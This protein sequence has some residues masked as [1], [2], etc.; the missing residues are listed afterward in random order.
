MPPEPLPFAEPFAAGLLDPA[1]AAPGLIGDAAGRLAGKRYDVYRNNVT[2]GLAKTIESIFPAVRHWVGEKTFRGLAIDH[3][4]AEPPSSPLLFDYGHGFADWLDRI[5]PP[6]FAGWLADLAR[7]ERL[8]LDAWHAADAAPLDPTALAAVLPEKLGDVRFVA[9]PAARMFSSRHAV[10]SLLRAGRGDGEAPADRNRPEAALVTR[11][12][13][14]VEV[15]F[16]PPGGA[17]FLTALIAGEPLG[18]A[19]AMA[20][21]QAPDIDIAAALA[22]MLAAGVFTR[23]ADA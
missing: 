4:R 10:V 20:L 1:I 2:M 14:D 17:A 12:A 5:A 8:W 7:L 6:E 21:D 23:L 19:A 15:R 18:V 11:P 3:A 9:H 22:A 16:L 13:F